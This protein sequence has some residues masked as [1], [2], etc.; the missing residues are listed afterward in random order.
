MALPVSIYEGWRLTDCGVGS[1]AGRIV[2]QPTVAKLL[3]PKRCGLRVVAAGIANRISGLAV[4]ADGS[5][6]TYQVNMLWFFTMMR[7]RRT[8]GASG[9]H[10]LNE[11]FTLTR[12]LLPVAVAILLV[13]PTASLASPQVS[14][15]TAGS[16]LDL[17]YLALF[18]ARYTPG[19]E[20]FVESII[21][22][23]GAACFLMREDPAEPG[24]YRWAVDL[25]AGDFGLSYLNKDLLVRAAPSPISPSSS[26]P[27]PSADWGPQVAARFGGRSKTLSIVRGV[28]INASAIYTNT[29]DV[30]LT[31]EQ[32]P[33]FIFVPF[34]SELVIAND[35]G[36]AGATRIATNP[37]LAAFAKNTTALE[38]PWK[39]QSS[40]SERL[41]KTVYVKDVGSDDIILD[42]TAPVIR[43]AS[44]SGGATA[45]AASRRYR[46]KVIASDSNSGVA[47]AQFARNKSRP[48]AT[49]PYKR[50]MTATGASKPKWVRVQDKAGNFSSWKKLK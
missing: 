24:T 37:T 18:E 28:S 20:V 14:R 15:P 16:V 21:G 11:Q 35:G 26:C 38:I 45:S 5:G 48:G 2:V 22:S 17:S 39:L 25:R 1:Q 7:M 46:V 9:R 44:L 32:G 43:S 50:T 23:F 34:A 49:I 42:E 13:V 40:G 8:S 27:G 19:K 6:G 41:P 10:G 31:V 33:Y 4:R 36:Y 3:K 12:L 47:K 30:K 29:P